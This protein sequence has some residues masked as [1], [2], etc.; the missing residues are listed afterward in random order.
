MA[1]RR[2]KMSRANYKKIKGV[3]GIYLHPPS[4]NYYGEKRIKGK[5][6]TATFKSVYEAKKWR[7]N[8]DGTK[9]ETVDESSECSTLAE[10]WGAIK[11]FH[12]PILATSTKNIWER[13]YSLLKNIEHLPMDKITPSKITEWVQYWVK[14][15]STDDYQNSGRGRSG[16]CNLH[17]ELNIFVTI[18]N[19]Y[20]ESEYF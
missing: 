16:R 12:F 6:F 1:Q 19:W 11:R 18:F 5:L 10:V 14:H 15:F 2:M 3:V 8:F 17:N 7:K 4:G 13:R 20:K 9:K